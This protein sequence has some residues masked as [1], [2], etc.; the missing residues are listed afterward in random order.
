M[1]DPTSADLEKT[2]S[3]KGKLSKKWALS[4]RGPRAPPSPRSA[5]PSHRLGRAVLRAV[6]IQLPPETP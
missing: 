6:I 2:L 5:T 3:N 1:S 4:S